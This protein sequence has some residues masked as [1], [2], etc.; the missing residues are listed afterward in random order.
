[1]ALWEPPE[2]F[3]L[4]SGIAPITTGA[5]LDVIFAA[6]GTQYALGWD[7]RRSRPPLQKLRCITPM[8]GMSDVQVGGG[9]MG[10]RLF[11]PGSA[12]VASF[13]RCG[14]QSSGATIRTS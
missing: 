3:L 2:P 9:P 6:A 14:Q 10:L 1:M 4:R 7:T 12:S 13:R 11:A 8:L 5:R